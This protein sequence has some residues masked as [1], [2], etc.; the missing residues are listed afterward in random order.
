M[1]TFIH[2]LRRSTKTSL[3][4]KRVKKLE[5]SPHDNTTRR[6]FGLLD[7]ERA[8]II[9]KVRT[10]SIVHHWEDLLPVSTLLNHRHQRC[11]II[12]ASIHEYVFLTGMTVEI[13]VKI[14]FA[15]FECLSYHLFN[16][17]A[18][19]EKLWTRVDIL[20]VEVMARQATSIVADDNTVRVQ[21]RHNFENISITKCHGSVI[22]ANKIL[23]ES[24]HDE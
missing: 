3:T 8:T 6:L 4:G 13:T 9:T 21:H 7:S 10:H 24:L 2:A 17:I 16:C 11:V 5:L 23:D 12:V 20:A 19:W 22:V 18:F 15:A 14:N 1:E